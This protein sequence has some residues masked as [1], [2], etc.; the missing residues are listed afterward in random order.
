[1]QERLRLLII[2]YVEPYFIV[3]YRATVHDKHN[4]PFA[5]RLCNFH[6]VYGKQSIATHVKSNTNYY[7]PCE[8]Q[9]YLADFEMRRLIHGL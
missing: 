1:M 6:C 8:Y 9:K 3:A 5:S 7:N 4:L 2:M